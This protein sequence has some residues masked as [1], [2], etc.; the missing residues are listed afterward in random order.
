MEN[1]IMLWAILTLILAIGG[2]CLFFY[3]ALKAN[4]NLLILGFLLTIISAAIGYVMKKKGLVPVP[5]K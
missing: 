3:G 5:T 2:I 1:K 4:S